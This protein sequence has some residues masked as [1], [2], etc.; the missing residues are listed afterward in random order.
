[1]AIHKWKNL[2]PVIGVSEACDYTI[3]ESNEKPAH[4]NALAS[5]SGIGG[6]EITLYKGRYEA[7]TLGITLHEMGHALG[8]RHMAG[9]LMA[10][11][12][13]YNVYK[14]PDAATVAQVAAANDVDPSLL[15]WCF[16]D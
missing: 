8:A 15:S 3:V 16:N 2:Q 4:P 10:P 14:C 12:A 6:R 5:T 7:D 13:Q 1:M 11:Q 9:T